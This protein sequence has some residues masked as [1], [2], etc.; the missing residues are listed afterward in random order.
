MADLV[1]MH[2]SELFDFAQI[3]MVDQQAGKFTTQN[4]R[5]L[6]ADRNDLDRLAFSEELAG[7]ITRQTRDL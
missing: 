2:K 4:I 5:A 7:M 3:N 1:G 6:L